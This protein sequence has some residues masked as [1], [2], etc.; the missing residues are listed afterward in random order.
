VARTACSRFHHAVELI[1]GRWTGPILRAVISG[2]H[3]Y[4]DIRDSTSGLSDTM[5]TQRL[6][7]L[8]VEGVLERRVLPTSPVHV[9]YHLTEKGRALSPVLETIARWA[10]EWVTDPSTTA[11]SEVP[12][13]SRS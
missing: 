9:E 3:R 8:E 11:R 12:W 1:G 4:A 5:L 2:R 10:D 7:E 13:P 6:R